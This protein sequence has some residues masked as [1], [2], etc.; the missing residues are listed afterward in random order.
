MKIWIE[1]SAPGL[2]LFGLPPLE[3]L[4]RNITKLA[5]TPPA[6]ILS[7]AVDARWPGAEHQPLRGSFG[8]RLRE[9]LAAS[10]DGLVVVDGRT[11][12]DPRLLQFLIG[13]T[14][15]CVAVRGEGDRRAAVLLLTS[16]LAAQIPEHAAN[17]LEVADALLAAGLIAPLRD[18][19]MPSFVAKLRRVLPYWLFAVPDPQARAEIERWMFWSNYKGSTDFLTRWVFP[20]V[21]WPLVRIS[22]RLGIH[23]NV[24][25]TFS[26]ILAF[27]AVPLF[28]SGHFLA[29]FIAAF[30]M[31]VLDS[32]DGKV[33]R[34]TLT[35]SVIG[36]VMDHGLDIVHPPFWY[37]SWAVGLGAV[38]SPDPL[39]IAMIALN[40]I[41]VADRLVLGVA[42]YR[43]GFGLHA[44]TQLD[45]RVRT[46]IAR[47]NTNMTIMVLALLIGQGALGF[48][49][50]T[51]WQGLTLL[52]HT[53]RTIWLG[54]VK[55]PL[56]PHLNKV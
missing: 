6:V 3:R 24:I 38:A 12:H 14:R 40:A 49:L 8:Q 43:L 44:A 4:R 55:R 13:H 25:T 36:D 29:G 27:A 41:Y 52:W 51:A 15:A 2:A 21:V 18:E 30:T 39:W 48:Y 22:T 17:L 50:V 42:K 45:T 23:P 9:S 26:I 34:V 35:D 20:P 32:V 47:R 11:A 53:A 31:A 37:W 1:G 56:I 46:F 28:A 33:A 19:D 10:A 7:G 16:D 5:A 54:F